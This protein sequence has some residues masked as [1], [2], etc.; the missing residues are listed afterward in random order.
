MT[1]DG[2]IY[3]IN[4]LSHTTTWEKP[5]LQERVVPQTRAARV[6]PV[7]QDPSLPEGWE[8]RLTPDGKV[9]YVDHNTRATSWEHPASLRDRSGSDLGP[10]P[11]GWEM[12]QMADGRLFFV[13]HTTHSTQ[14]EDPRLMAKN[15]PTAKMQYNRDY[16]QK[17]TN[18]RSKLPK[19]PPGAPNCLELPVR[20][21]HL[22][23]DSFTAVKNVRPLNKFHSRL[24]VKFSGEQG[25]D[26]GGLARE[27]FYL[28]SHEMFSP[29]YGLF[30]YAAR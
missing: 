8:Q 10:M 16:K 11:P 6:V 23:E 17:Y 1:P 4:H 20:R 21:D 29:Y 28:L 15:K 30:E 18:F 24:Y 25:L 22:F 5:R 3:Y 9:Y 19:P 27:W 14:W 26:Y 13:D 12:K 2:R 7:E